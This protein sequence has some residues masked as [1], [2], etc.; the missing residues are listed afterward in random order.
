MRL[1]D[2]I[3]MSLV[4]ML[5]LFPFQMGLIHMWA[6]F[7]WLLKS[8][9][10]RLTL[11]TMPS[12]PGLI[13]MLHSTIGIIAASAE[14]SP[15]HQWKASHGVFLHFKEKT[16]FS[17]ANTFTNN[18]H[19]WHLFLIL[20]HITIRK[21][22]CVTFSIL[23]MDIMWLLSYKWLFK[24]LWVQQPPPTITWGPWTRD[25]QYESKKNIL[26]QQFRVWPL[27]SRKQ[28]WNKS[29]TPFPGSHI[30]LK[31]KE[32]NETANS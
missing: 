3:F 13:L 7:R 20:W 22:T 27:A 24:L 26:P 16:F 5:L 12:C 18:N 8:W 11:K 23:T 25:P 2:V 28:L 6:C 32:G 31:E 29:D 21:W 9:V 10:C 1:S 19:M 15:P 14:H 4:S 30:L 17:L